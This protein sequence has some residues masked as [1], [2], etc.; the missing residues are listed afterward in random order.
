MIRLLGWFE[1][2]PEICLALPLLLFTQTINISDETTA[3]V[4]QA[5]LENLA[6]N[7]VYVMRLERILIIFPRAD[8]TLPI[9]ASSSSE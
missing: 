8:L 5:L 3:L 1:I 7:E 2:L 4:I 6:T 9:Y